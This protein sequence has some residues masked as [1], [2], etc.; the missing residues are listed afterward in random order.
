VA[1]ASNRLARQCPGFGARL[2]EPQ[3][4]GLQIKRLRV[5]DPRSISKSGHHRLLIRSEIS[6]Y[7]NV[8]AVFQNYRNVGKFRRQFA[9]PFGIA[10]FSG[11]LNNFVPFAGLA[12]RL[13]W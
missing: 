8:A 1:E 2:C 11:D 12:S 9:V 7:A 10:G 5:T 6:P 13:Q 4:V 3:H